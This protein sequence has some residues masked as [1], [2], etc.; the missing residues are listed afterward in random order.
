[1]SSSRT[2]LLAGVLAAGTGLT[3]WW[4]TRAPRGTDEPAVPSLERAAGEWAELHRCALG[5]PL[6]PGE[7]TRQRARRIELAG[8]GRG[9]GGWPGRC[10]PHARALHDALAEQP[11]LEVLRSELEA[12]LGCATG[13]AVTDPG[14]Q[15]AGLV[16]QANALLPPAVATG[17]PPPMLA[18]RLLTRDALPPLGD[19]T[20]RV[21]DRL[22]GDDGSVRVLFSGPS[23]SWSACEIQ[24]AT[25]PE[26]TCSRLSVEPGARA[27]LVSA[28]EA[29]VRMQQGERIRHID[30]QSGHDVEVTGGRRE[31]FALGRAPE[32]QPVVGRLEAGRVSTRARPAADG[33]TAGPWLVA[34]QVA[35]VARDG[36]WTSQ[37]LQRNGDLL[38]PVQRAAVVA[39]TEEPRWCRHGAT[40]LG[41][42]GTQ[43]AVLLHDGRWHPFALA[44]PGAAP[45]PPAAPPATPPAT[46]ATSAR[47][48]AARE[49]AQTGMAAL[50]AAASS[51]PPS[52]WGEPGPAPSSARPSPLFPAPRAAADRPRSRPILPRRP[53]TCDDDGGTLWWRETSDAGEVIARLRCTP[54]GCREDRAR[55]DGLDVKSWWLATGLGEQVLAVWQTSLGDVRLR[56]A[57]LDALATAPDR[58][59]LDSQHHEGPDT[60]DLEAFVTAGGVVFL[61]RD[62]GPR[63]FRIGVGGEVE[64]L[65]RRDAPP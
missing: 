33:L 52:P 25:G 3:V 41:V 35:W 12:R 49:A 46:T 32:G 61:F 50:L 7:T 15:L 45:A 4:A 23:G 31:G 8:G 26:V 37:A 51:T 54:S 30:A 40:A 36:A 39:T 18:E 27:S 10:D 9:L 14:A 16:E 28:S 22:A 21:E 17:A 11:S 29:V 64:P 59:L 2:R 20:A 42:F 43:A 53:L 55:L 57:P 6:D 38:G 58:A 44:S 5:P 60:Q 48:E 34:D 13:C 24:P 1:M 19:P 65:V 63:G 62:Q 56:L 47:A